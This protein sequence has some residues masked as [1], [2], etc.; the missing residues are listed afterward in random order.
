MSDSNP[1]DV[2]LGEGGWTKEFSFLFWSLQIN[3]GSHDKFVESEFSFLGYTVTHTYSKGF[4]VLTYVL[5]LVLLS[6]ACLMFILI[7]VLSNGAMEFEVFGIILLA[8]MLIYGYLL[9]RLT[10][11]P[12]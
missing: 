10:F 12:P 6:I 8:F 2:E 1:S 7:G 11:V 4:W 9:Y 3:N 5:S